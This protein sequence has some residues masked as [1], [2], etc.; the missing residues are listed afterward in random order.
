MNV[1]SLRQRSHLLQWQLSIAWWLLWSLWNRLS[2]QKSWDRRK[3]PEIQWWFRGHNK[4]TLKSSQSFKR[5]GTSNRK[6]LE[7]NNGFEASWVERWLT[8]RQ[9]GLFPNGFLENLLQRR[10]SQQQH[11]EHGWTPGEGAIQVHKHHVQSSKRYFNCKPKAFNLKMFQIL[12]TQA[13]LAVPKYPMWRS[14]VTQSHCNT[15]DQ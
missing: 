5:I 9:W 14:Y 13:T 12:A 6:E 11:L 2:T 8:I 1:A 10:S 7:T 3:K 4:K 15:S